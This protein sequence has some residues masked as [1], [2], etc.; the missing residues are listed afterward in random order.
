M[1]WEDT[2]P[3][4]HSSGGGLYTVKV[5]ATRVD[6][7]ICGGVSSQVIIVIIYYH[8]DIQ[9]LMKLPILIIYNITILYFIII[10]L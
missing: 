8:K 6:V 5:H 7:I 9:D 4:L 10:L 1:Y 2:G 3:L